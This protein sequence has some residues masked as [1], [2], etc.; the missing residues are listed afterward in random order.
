[1]K[2]IRILLFA[3]FFAPIAAFAQTNEF[4]VAAQLL[5]AA[6]NADIQQVQILINSGADV[7]YIDKTGLSLVCTALMNND[8]RAAQILQMYGADASQCDKQIKQYR[9]RATKTRGTVTDGGGGLF[10]G[11]SSAQSLTLTAAGAAVVIGGLFLLTDVLD[12]DNG[13][14]NGG[15]G[16]GDR[17]NNGGGDSGGG[18]ATGGD[19]IPV[20][21][22][23]F[24]ANGKVAYSIEKY[25]TNLA[26]WN[27]VPTNVG[28]RSRDFNFFRPNLMVPDT[29]SETGGTVKNPNSFETAGIT[30]PMQNYLLM[31]HGYSA[32]ANGYMGQATFRNT[33][34]KAPLRGATNN[35][36]SGQ[37]IT[38]GLIT[39]NGINPVGSL[40]RSND[41]SFVDGGV[42]G[43]G[44]T[45]Y[46]SAD[47][48]IERLVDKFLNYENPSSV[49]GVGN[50]GKEFDGFDLSNSGTAMNP[51]VSANDNALGKIIAGWDKRSDGAG[52]LYGFVP[53]GRLGVFR[54]GGG[55]AWKKLATPSELGVIS[56]GTGGVA[57]TVQ[58]GDTIT[59]DGK[60]YK[61]VSATDSSITNPTITIGGK[62]FNVAPGSSMLVAKC[63]SVVDGT[64]DG[65]SDMAIY[66]GTNNLY[67]VN[68]SGG[69][70]PDAVFSVTDDKLMSE[71]EYVKT[72][73]KN[74]QAMD[75]ARQKGVNVIA[76]TSVN[77][78][79]RELGYYKMSDMPGLIAL[80]GGTKTDAFIAAVNKYYEYDDA[81]GTP[82]GNIANQLFGAYPPASGT[83]VPI[84]VNPA[85]EFQIGTGDGAS[86]S[87]LDATFENYAPLLYPTLEHNFMTV[88]AVQHTK[89]TD[90]ADSIGAYGNGTGSSYGPLYLSSWQDGEDGPIY[91]SRKCGD[92]GLGLNGIDPWCFAA[93]GPT[94]EMAAASAAGAVAAVRG[95][96]TYM[97]N[98]QIFALMALTADGAYLGT[99]PATGG[100]WGTG[101][102]NA[103][104]ALV[105]YLKSMYSLPP[106][107]RADDAL[108]GDNYLRAFRE[109]Y[110]YGLINLERAL[111]P[112]KKIYY[113]NGN[114]IVSASGN[115]YWRAASAGT[116]FRASAAFAPRAATI[117]APFFDILESVD[118][119]LS[120]PRIWQNEFTI[121]SAD[122]RG[123]YM[124]DVLG[125]FKTRRDAPMRTQIG[126][127]GFSMAT[128]QRAYDD[129][130][131]GLDAMR[132]DYDIGNWDLA[133]G[134]QR[135]MTDGAS[136]FSGASNPIFG[137]A[138]NAITSD[139]HYN[140]GR[141][142]FGARAFAGT[143]TDE[144]LLENDPTLS[145]RYEP[146]HLGR[147]SGAAGD[148]AF[149]GDKFTFNASIGTARESDT[150]LGAQTGGL[151]NLGAGDTT[152]V[153]TEMRYNLRDDV[154]FMMRS[155][156]ARTT[157]NATGEFILG[158][159]DIESDA[160]AVGADI[161]NFS[162]VISRPLGV[163]RGK[164]Q[165]A[166][167][168]YD[169]VD[170]DDGKYELAVRDT[171]VAD[172]DLS[173]AHR[174]LRF[175]GEYR[176]KLGEFTDGAIGFIYRVNPNH[177]SDF[178]NESIF[179]LKMT[180]RLGI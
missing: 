89:G 93:A 15:A 61:I 102:A 66:R 149:S 167:A 1:M 108:D 147:I 53:N 171:H 56:K 37:P 157:G 162:F 17:P 57:N 94:T 84:I 99:N 176:R 129:N 65:V 161:G 166:H 105:A 83:N 26:Q 76:N 75:L 64:C 140:M 29:S 55:Y 154:S 131:G 170:T 80:G 100:A 44:I 103:T 172:I 110:G 12:S 95:A 142:S 120:M 22:A 52:D 4:M 11:L 180:H 54:T 127:I 81:D 121:G 174:E 116:T 165:Y 16:A 14:D 104:A 20:G 91:Q 62:T 25:E 31:M 109:V 45:Y 2:Y 23:Y 86:A 163:N 27:P 133:A 155:T 150:I 98:D 178:G 144:T 179:M 63:E 6:K 42:A 35:A 58:V 156:F 60:T 143:I 67:Y 101:A 78:K 30:L 73:V 97:S 51:F 175:S 39:A 160:F 79:S 9:S 46:D 87:V 168:E 33:S 164:L 148:A 68:Y 5:S 21:P 135:H 111:T 141:W 92:A 125:E 10:S 113:Y 124:G 71:M 13:N 159:S 136:R 7:N 158:M 32:F 69:N 152:Y 82:Q 96:F 130:L 117:S 123:L 106:E 3:L 132:F 40:V 153:D 119:E 169:I 59:A 24:D 114:D 139:A 19:A 47:G 128:S 85:G 28:L 41:E 173:P 151:L 18:T 74:Y 90:A 177:T 145:A 77:P 138:S 112:G 70:R 115:A 146:A 122:R 50:L 137:L 126:N 107:Y 34:T 43:N 118:G 8:V 88:V 38:V 72:D 49:S 36:T 48:S 134:Y